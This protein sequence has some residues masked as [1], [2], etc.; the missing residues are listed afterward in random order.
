MALEEHICGRLH[1]CHNSYKMLVKLLQSC[2]E[3]QQLILMY[4]RKECMLSSSVSALIDADN[5]KFYTC[6]YMSVSYI[7]DCL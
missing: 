3:I 1:W 4:S 2:D 6:K 5:E 7:E